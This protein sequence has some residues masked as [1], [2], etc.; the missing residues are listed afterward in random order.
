VEEYLAVNDG[1]RFEIRQ[2]LEASKRLEVVGRQASS[3]IRASN[4]GIGFE[5]AAE[6]IGRAGGAAV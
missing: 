3:L 1:L 2:M 6:E 4:Y 5:E